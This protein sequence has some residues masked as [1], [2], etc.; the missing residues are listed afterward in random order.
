MSTCQ[1]IAP[2]TTPPASITSGPIS[3]RLGGVRRRVFRSAM[4]TPR[5]I[6]TYRIETS[7]PLERA[8]ESKAGE[9]STGTFVRVPGE[10][11]ELRDRF[12]ARV[13]RITELEEVDHTSLPGSRP[14]KGQAGPIR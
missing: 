12:G 7:H 8:A 14:P 4:S 1:S 9:Q 10:T 3:A 13:E 5:I 6:A 11:D 2:A